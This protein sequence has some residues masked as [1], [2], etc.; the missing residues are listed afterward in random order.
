MQQVLGYD[1]GLHNSEISATSTLSAG[2]CSNQW[3]HLVLWPTDIWAEGGHPQPL[4]PAA[5]CQ[6]R[7]CTTS[8]GGSWRRRGDGTDGDVRVK[9]IWGEG[10]SWQWK[11]CE[12]QWTECHSFLTVKAVL[13]EVLRDCPSRDEHGTESLCFMTQGSTNCLN[14]QLKQTKTKKTVLLLMLSPVCCS[15]DILWH[16]ERFSFSVFDRCFVFRSLGWCL[17]WWQTCNWI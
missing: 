10:I 11:L 1:G 16:H 9:G 13:G 17:V 8:R 12:K 4:L 14:G 5:H 2:N 3:N 7:G 15:L 6:K